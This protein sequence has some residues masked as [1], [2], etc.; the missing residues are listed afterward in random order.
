MTTQKTSPTLAEQVLTTL[1]ERRAYQQPVCG[2]RVKNL[3]GQRFG[4]L[5]VIAFLGRHKEHTY[6]ACQCDC[7][8]ITEARANSLTRNH[9][10]SCGCVSARLTAE[11]NVKHGL[12]RTPIYW[13]WQN[14]IQRCTN[15]NHPGY[16]NYG[17]RGIRV[18]DG[19]LN[20]FEA[21]YAVVGDPQ[22]GLS[23]DR[24]DNN[25]NYEPGNVRWATRVEQNHNQRPR[26]RRGAT[27]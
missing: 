21:F 24:K 10:R 9:S 6:W 2:H 20:S 8:V 3:T 13:C 26:R 14:M 22:P 16:V 7:G 18:C 4:H 19:W 12:A 5:E 27:A 11:Q 15:P 1:L 23:L 17:A 25:G